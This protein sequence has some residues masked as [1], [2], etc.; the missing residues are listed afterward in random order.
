MNTFYN[1]FCINALSD[2]FIWQVIFYRY[3]REGGGLCIVDEVQT[4]LGRTGENFWAFQNQGK[5]CNVQSNLYVKDTQG[6]LKMC[7]LWA[8]A[9]YIQVKI[10]RTFHEWAIDDALYRQWFVI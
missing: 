6:N 1:A 7:L 8:V 4:G 5:V 9:L 2:I 3:V 10:I